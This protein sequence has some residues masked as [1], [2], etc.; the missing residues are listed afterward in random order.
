MTSIITVGEI[1]SFITHV[2]LSVAGYLPYP[3]GTISASAIP[4]TNHISLTAAVASDE[5]LYRGTVITANEGETAM[6]KFV[7]YG[8]TEEVRSILWGEMEIE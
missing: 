5:V 8:F 2:H 4:L 3:S 7:D 6:I 1:S